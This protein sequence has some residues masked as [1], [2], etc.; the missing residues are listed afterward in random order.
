[1]TL[2]KDKLYY[3]A[4]PYSK[5][6]CGPEAAFND[7][8]K[9]AAAL[10]SAKVKVF[11]PITHSHPIVPYLVKGVDTHE[12]WLGLDEAIMRGCDGL[13]VAR[14]SGWKQSYG[15]NWEINWFKE[16]KGVEPIYID[17]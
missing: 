9:I 2:D 8:A 1:M 4:S 17:P 10:I 5:Y 6:G 14:M 15:V 16:N 3:L 13:I 12:T 11:C 7:I